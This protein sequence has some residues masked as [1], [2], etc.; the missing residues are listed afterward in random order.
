MKKS[1]TLIELLVVIAIIAI[2]AAMLLP[3]LQ[4]ARENG[5]KTTCVNNFGTVGKYAAFYIQD[6][7]GFFP[8]HWS[9]TART[10]LPRMY[11]GHPGSFTPY[12]QWKYTTEYLGGMC[13]A[14]G[15]ININSLCCPTVTPA[16]ISFRKYQPGPNGINWPL[17]LNQ[18]FIGI[19]TN[20]YLARL[21][22]DAR[23]VKQGAIR[24][25]GILIYKACGS[26]GGV[27]SYMT[28][29][30]EVLAASYQNYSVGL[31]H[32]GGTVMSY[33]DFHVRYLKEH[34][35]PSYKHGWTWNGPIFFSRP[36]TQK[37]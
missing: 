24:K 22:S 23:P 4:Q 28:R 20:F 8:Y 7:N 36:E 2:L 37:W 19:S 26:G 32:L 35:V 31:R 11:D 5:K 21:K 30:H 25:P 27:M 34:E 33:A 17:D 16:M 1:F 10:Y 3:A 14:S 9:T 12:A 18:R 13:V 15:K 6:N 29:Y